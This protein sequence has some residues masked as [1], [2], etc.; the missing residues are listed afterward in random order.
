MIGQLLDRRYQVTQELSQG[1]FG[2]TFLAEDT[3]RPRNPVCVV[4]QLHPSH[5][6]T[7]VL[8]KAKE[9]FE[10]EANILLSLGEHP[11]IPRLLAYFEE[12]DEFYLVEEY[13]AGKSL[14]EE[15]II[16]QSLPEK[17]VLEILVELLQ[18]LNFVHGNNVIHRDIKP[19][20]I[21]IREE[22]KKLVLID[23]GAVKQATQSGKTKETVI[24]T[25]GYISIEQAT[26]NPKFSSDIYAVG[27]ICI[28]ALTGHE[29][30]EI[31]RDYNTEKLLWR[32][33][34]EVSDR[35]ANILDK[36]VA[37]NHQDRYFSAKEALE[38]VTQTMSNLDGSTTQL[39]M[40]ISKPTNTSQ[41]TN[42]TTVI[43]GAGISTPDKKNKFSSS[44]LV[45]VLSGLVVV[46]GIFII[47]NINNV[48]KPQLSLDGKEI[49][50]V[51]TEQDKTEP[52]TTDTPVFTPNQSKGISRYYQFYH[53]KGNK[54]QKIMID[55]ASKELDPYLKLISPDSI[56]LDA[57]DDISPDNSNARIVI[58]L[59]DNG[60]YKVM[61][62][63]SQ[64]GETGTYQLSAKKIP[65]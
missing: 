33:M 13:I 35:L 63:S 1:G 22:D 21:I 8:N 20:N 31:P 27:I 7:N 16:G 6:G 41:G 43:E 9:L 24:G 34:A 17:R 58:T 57:Q 36:M 32:N 65:N 23:F 10:R 60:I 2:R 56:V 15:L 46:I 12:D 54:G 48:P 28:Q 62:T 47:T 26:G 25:P 45:G 50:G 11:Q 30:L 49:T 55:M 14:S 19:D 51:L 42:A 59:P 38:A 40:T 4:K 64:A 18:I 37:Y 44:L 52:I 5:S 39:M 3:K 29:P 53:F 61:V